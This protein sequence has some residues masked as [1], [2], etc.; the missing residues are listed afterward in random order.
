[1]ENIEVNDN[2]KNLKELLFNNNINQEQQ[3]C[4]LKII[5]ST[6]KGENIELVVN[7][8]ISPVLCELPIIEYEL[9]L[10]IINDYNRYSQNQNISISK[11]YNLIANGLVKI[12][13]NQESFKD[14][15]DRLVLTINEIV[16]CNVN[17]VNPVVNFC[18]NENSVYYTEEEYRNIIYY[19]K[20]LENPELISNIFT[21][22]N[23]P[24]IED[25]DCLFSL[26]KEEESIIKLKTEELNKEGI[27][28]KKKIKLK[29]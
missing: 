22:E 25:K 8:A 28:K 9:I 17:L 29:N 14:N 23:V 15:I 10:K 1:M 4:A 12:L 24:F 5:N 21:N 19:I 11:L 13:Y 16:S 6:F 18:A 7:A 26:S 27:L 3:Q 20:Y 2:N